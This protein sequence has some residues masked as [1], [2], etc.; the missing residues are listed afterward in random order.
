M[1][2]K[3]DINRRVQVIQAKKKRYKNNKKKGKAATGNGLASSNS[4]AITTSAPVTTT[5]GAVT[6]TTTTNSTT[7]TATTNTQQPIVGDK[8]M[9]RSNAANTNNVVDN[10]DNSVTNNANSI[11]NSIQEINSILSKDVSFVPAH[12]EEVSHCATIRC[13]L[14]THLFI[15]FCTVQHFDAN[16]IAFLLF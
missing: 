14:H 6:T 2:S 11:L 10:I 3:K 12:Q 9:F 13:S 1:N 15:A 7:T 8:N 4:T 5:A 16:E